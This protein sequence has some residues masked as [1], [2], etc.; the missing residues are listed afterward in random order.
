[1]FDLISNRDGSLIYRKIGILKEGE[2]I[3][4]KDLSKLEKKAGMHVKLLINFDYE[5]KPSINA[6]KDILS[7]FLEKYP[8]GYLSGNDFWWSEENGEKIM[9]APLETMN[10]QYFPS[11]EFLSLAFV[12]YFSN[13]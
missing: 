9:H 12:N 13:F 5:K 11:Y 6:T 8:G 3:I 2:T 4:E 10:L 7:G 1:M